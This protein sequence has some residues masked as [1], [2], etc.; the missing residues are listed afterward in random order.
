MLVEKE[1]AK[2]QSFF[3]EQSAFY[4]HGLIGVEESTAE[5]D[6]KQKNRLLRE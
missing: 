4:Q 6:E 2:N 3:F 5:D 1:T